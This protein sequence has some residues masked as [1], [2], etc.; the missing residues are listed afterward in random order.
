M[1]R[2]C[3]IT[4]AIP[5]V[6][7][8]PH[9]G[10]A[11]ELV[12][13]DVLAR[14]ARLRGWEVR[15]Q[16]GT[17]ENSAKNLAAADAAGVS[18][19]RLVDANAAAYAALR[20]PLQLSFDDFIRTSDD[21]RHRPGVERLW[22]AC[23]DAGDL[24][25]KAYEGLYCA[26]CEQFSAPGDLG[27]DG[28]CP[29][30]GVAPEPVAEENWF[31][32][33][34][35]YGGF[36]HD[37]ISS[38]RLRIQP[39]S[40]RN[41]ALAFVAGGL[42]DF[43]VSRSAARSRGWGI[44]VPGDPDQVVYVWFDALA[45]YITALDDPSGGR[46]G[47][48]RWWVGADRRVH[49]IGKGILRFHAVYWP[50]IL[51]SAGV[52]PPT[53]IVVHDYLTVGGRKIG[54]SLG[55]AV[56]PIELVERYGTDALRWWLVRDVPRAGDADFTEERLVERANADLANG[57]GNLAGRVATLVHRRLGGS[58]PQRTRA[59]DPGD[60]RLLDA[61]R[62]LPDEIDDAIDR[63]DLRRASGALVEL[64]AEANRHLDAVQPWRLSGDRL[65]AALAALIE[66]CRTVG[67]ELGPFLPTLAAG[68]L[69]RFGGRTGGD[70]SAEPG[71]LFARIA[72]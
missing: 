36:L 60:R 46:D 39:E 10:F 51:A 1:T 40:R 9:L 56:D 21:P 31:F 58:L 43:S 63:F 2:R 24:Y 25:R 11:L 22:R 64:V 15:F 29:E 65:E 47:Y 57:F 45:N 28:R 66:T 30:H 23:A 37:Q 68:L 48:R 42:E 50:A 35:R 52:A 71:P 14:H 18:P 33:L 34:S 13:A 54:K 16:T 6:N 32:R 62:R 72:I 17:D 49:V 67:V 53:D 12:Q 38:G 69:E 41:E 55:N 5:F 19:R 4:T 59:D 44:P 8:A 26:G 27:P 20:Q 61:A 70:V 3:N 7:A